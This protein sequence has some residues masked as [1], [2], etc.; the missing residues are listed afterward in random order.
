MRGF[1]GPADFGPAFF[2]SS[3][4]IGRILPVYQMLMNLRV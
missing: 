1:F 2:N 3:R 4:F